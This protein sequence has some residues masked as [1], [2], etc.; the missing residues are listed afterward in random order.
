MSKARE[1]I[2]FY[3]AWIDTDHFLFEAFGPTEREARQFL[4]D[5]FD[6]HRE[7]HGIKERDWWHYYKADIQVQQIALGAS[8]RDHEKLTSVVD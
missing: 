1:E 8:Y 2:A 7:Q 3:R 5:G 4:R 6:K